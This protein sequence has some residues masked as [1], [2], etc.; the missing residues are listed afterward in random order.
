MTKRFLEDNGIGFEEFDIKAEGQEAFSEFYRAHRKVIHRGEDGV[1]FPVFTDG[2]VIHQ[3]VGAVIA[4]LVGGEKLLGFVGQSSLHGEW[5]DGFNISG[6][7]PRS[8]EGLLSVL[9]FLKQNNLKVQAYS[10]GR[11]AALLQSVLEKNLADRVVV[12]VKGPAGLYESLGG[13]AIDEGELAATLKTAV[14][15]PEYQFFTAIAPLQRDNGT[16]EYLTPQEIGTTAEQIEAATGSK[17]HPYTLRIFNPQQAGEDRF[18][19]LEP[20]PDSDKFKYRTAAR[21]YMVMTEIE[22]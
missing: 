5:I 4:F 7:D 9:A 14:R 21:R 2:D 15:F 19:S 6:G 22:K 20:M 18:K 3:G 12:E 17:K 16:I 1:E 8:A 10:D 13:A 11:N